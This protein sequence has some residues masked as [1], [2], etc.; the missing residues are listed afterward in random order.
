MTAS[1]DA[2]RQQLVDNARARAGDGPVRVNAEILREVVKIQP[3][4]RWAGLE[5]LKAEDGQ[6][7][8][9]IVLRP[10]EMTQHHGFLHGG[11]IGFLAD[12]A[13]AYAAATVVGD[14]LS[15]QYTIHFLSP[16]VG[17]AF[18]ARARV[19]K[20]GKRQVVVSVEVIAEQAEGEKLIATASALILPAGAAAIG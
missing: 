4:E 10:D 17:E 18:R 7:E 8:T 15:A 13:A 2:A 5:V 3:F 12:N 9:R 11:L 6:V 1:S 19:V 14:V 16:G 20:A